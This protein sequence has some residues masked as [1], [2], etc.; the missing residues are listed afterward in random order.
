MTTELKPCPF[1]GSEAKYHE[2]SGEYQNYVTCQNKDCGMYTYGEWLHDPTTIKRWNTRPAREPLKLMRYSIFTNIHGWNHEEDED[3]DYVLYDQALDIFTVRL[4]REEELRQ[5]FEKELIETKQQLKEA[6]KEIETAKA[7]STCMCGSLICE[8]GVWDGHSPV[9]MYSHDKMRL[10]EQVQSLE[11]TIKKQEEE[12]LQ[13]K[14]VAKYETDV[15]QSEIEGR[16]E[17]QAKV[18]SLEAKLAE[19][20]N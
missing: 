9:S 11:E 18:K 5:Y 8:H 13:W 1:C 10:E 4:S 3:G 19:M 2:D 12:V 7:L 20:G 15:A 17:L 14:L 16:K 6:V